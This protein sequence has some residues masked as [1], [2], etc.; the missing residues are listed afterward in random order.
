MPVQKTSGQRMNASPE[1]FG[2]AYEVSEQWLYA[3]SVYFRTVAVCQSLE[4]PVAACQVL[5]VNQIA[6][7][8]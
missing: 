6:S 2:Q 7:F 4:R 3:S 5:K 1:F 8:T